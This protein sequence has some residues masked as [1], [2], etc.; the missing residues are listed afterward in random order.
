MGAVAASTVVAGGILA[1]LLPPDVA[2][3]EAWWDEEVIGDALPVEAAAVRGAV[4]RRREDLRRGRACARRA[5][6]AQGRPPV[7][8]PVGEHRQPLWP[9]GIVG[10]ITHCETYCAAAIAPGD[11]IGTVGIDA[12]PDRPL[13]DGV[14]EM[15]SSPEE[16]RW[17]RPA[18]GGTA[19]DTLLFSAKEAVYKAWFPVTGLWL[20]FTQTEIAADLRTGGFVA[21][22]DHPAVVRHSHLRTLHGRFA[23]ARGTIIAA[24][25]AP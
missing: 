17:A 3:C 19:Y 2:T 9:K 21:R 1:G 16:R 8:I 6:G 22:I 18:A 25:T 20:D 13:P 23:V 4:P 12:E 11:V 10:S 5:L 14:L 15:I 7:A 24:L